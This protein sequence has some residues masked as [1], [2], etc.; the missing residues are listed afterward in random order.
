MLSQPL[1]HPPLTA[2]SVPM[3]NLFRPDSQPIPRD[4]L[5]I[6]VGALA[7]QRSYLLCTSSFYWPDCSLHSSEPGEYYGSSG[8]RNQ[9]LRYRQRAD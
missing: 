4:I 3:Y 9:T 6:S 7:F 1:G 8:L 2:S 5:Y